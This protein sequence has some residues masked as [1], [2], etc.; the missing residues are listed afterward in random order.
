MRSKWHSQLLRVCGGVLL[1]LAAFTSGRAQDVEIVAADSVRAE[2]VPNKPKPFRKD[3]IR[4]AV[5]VDMSALPAP[6]NRLRAYQATLK[7]N[8]DV[9]QF[10]DV[11]PAP[12]P[13][14]TPNLNRND[15]AAGRI[16]WN[17]FVTSGT[18]GKINIL[19]LS[20]EV[21]GQPGDSTILDLNFSEMTNTMLMSLL[22]VLVTKDGKVIVQGN[23]PPDIAD[24]GAQMMNEGAT[25]EVPLS[26]TD[27]DRDQLKFSARNLPAFATLTD[28]GNG[29]G[30][31]RFKPGRNESGDYP[32]IR[33]FVTDNG[34]PNLQDSTGFDLKVNNSL[35]PLVCKIEIVRRGGGT[36]CDASMEVCVSTTI[37]GTVGPS[38]KICTV[39]GVPVL[40]GC[41]TIPIVNGANKIVARLTVK[42]SLETCVAADSVTVIGRLSPLSCTLNL[43][44]PADSALV[45]SENVDVKGMASIAG[46]IIPLTSKVDVNGVPATV[47]GN[48]F[49]VPVKLSPG[50]NTL[51]ATFAVTDSCKNTAVCRDTIRV[52]SIIDKIAPGCE[53]TPGFKSVTGTL[54]DNESGIAKVEAVFLFNAKLTVDPFK[55]GAKQVNFRLD[56]LGQQPYLGFDI[57]ITDLCGNT[58]ICDPVFLQLTADRAN[59]P[60]VFT[61]RS[62]DRYF[63]LKNKGLTEVRVELNGKRFS[64]STQRRGGSVQ[65]LGVYAMPAE[66]EVTLDLQTYLRDSGDNDIRIEVAGPVGSSAE[67]LLINEIHDAE[68]ALALQGVPL[69]YE[70]SQN[71]PNPFNPETVIR[72]GIPLQVTAG[73]PVQLRIYNMLG[74]LVRTL[75][76]EPM[77]PGHYTARWNGRN[78]R[79]VPVAAGVYIY[80]IVAG[81]YSAAKRM[82]LLK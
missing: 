14:D 29:T 62:I 42:D 31:L 3:T 24:L 72:F 5:N 68:H 73:T 60:Y 18:S 34:A 37:T 22:N 80:R 25:L 8:K 65:S 81:D 9:I 75:V 7:W 39:N 67:L 63:Q 41:V 55:P 10:L 28:N 70:L 35:P 61:F 49:S 13:W 17:D 12:A 82:L 66:G 52:R 54:F 45:C 38:T 26:A 20:F 76:D 47:T 15:V 79:G 51:I 48:A 36:S 4:V 33:V 46:G 78:D 71:Y 53:F 40:T 43:T 59:N 64:F 30:V 19:N 44:A 32:N 11:I 16:E 57:K 50:W 58:H 27:P 6:N 1:L 69:I 21:V 56:D 23:R 2:S 77:P 74:E